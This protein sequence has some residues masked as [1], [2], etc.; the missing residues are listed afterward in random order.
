MRKRIEKT[1][2]GKVSAIIPRSKRAKYDEVNPTAPMGEETVE[3]ALPSTGDSDGLA[4]IVSSLLKTMARIDSSEDESKEEDDKKESEDELLTRY[5]VLHTRLKALNKIFGS[6][7]GEDNVRNLYT[8]RYTKG[9]P[10]D[11]YRL[12]VD[13]RL[14]GF[15]SNE[16]EIFPYF[17][18]KEK[19]DAYLQLLRPMLEEY[20]NLTLTLDF[21]ELAQK[22]IKVIH[23]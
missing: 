5:V 14:R 22:K 6:I 12:L 3:S 11:E 23:K 17:L 19:A 2:H 7:S 1:E 8:I 15:D 16:I 13:E 4:E 10:E 20:V 21:V 18:E 9:A